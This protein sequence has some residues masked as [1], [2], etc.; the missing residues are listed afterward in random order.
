MRLKGTKTELFNALQAQGNILH[1]GVS[2]VSHAHHWTAT[3]SAGH[4]DGVLVALDRW[5]KLDATVQ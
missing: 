4:P 1:S 5:T 3:G 2:G